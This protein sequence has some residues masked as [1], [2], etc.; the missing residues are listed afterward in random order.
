MP[1]RKLK[2]L[3]RAKKGDKFLVIRERGRGR[4]IVKKLKGRKK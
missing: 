3:P 1:S 2:G 4:F